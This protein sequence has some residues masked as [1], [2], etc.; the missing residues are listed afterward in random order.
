VT[1]KDDQQPAYRDASLPVEERVADLL[2]RMTLDE[3]VSQMVAESAAIPRLGIPAYEW[4]GECLHGLCQGGR[5]TVFPQAIGLAATFDVD[6][7]RRVAGAIADEARAKFHDPVWHGPDGPFVGLTFWTPVVNIFRDPRWGRGQETYGEDPHLTGAIG[8]AF[9][10]GLQGDDARRVKASACAKHFAVHSGPEHLRMGFDAVV[11]GKDLRETYLPAFRALAEAGVECFMGAYNRVN[12][13]PCC[14]SHMLLVDILRDE[15]GFEGYVVSDASA[16]PAFHESHHVTGDAVESAAL[17]LRM[18]CDMDIGG[19]CFPELPAAVEKGLV[20]EAEVDRSLARLLTSRFRL[21]LFDDPDDVPFAAIRSDVIQ[22][23]E[24]VALARE[25]AVK[26]VVLLKNSGILPF[27]PGV[28]TV[29][30]TGPN[31]ADLDVLLG[32][33]Y[34]G[35]S[36]RLV[37]VLE[38]VAECASEGTRISNAKGCHLLHP[39]EYPSDWV[40]GLAEWA[41]VV[42]AVMGIS[43]LMEGEG[44]ECIASV[45][46]G[47]RD[48]LA[49]PP[50]QVEFVRFL[51]GKG[52]PIVLV[53]T[54]GS[55]VAAPELHEL[56]DAVLFIWYPGEQGGRAV[57]QILFGHES[58]SGRLPVT[59]PASQDQVPPFE[60]YSMAGRTYRYMAEEPLYPFGFGLSYAEFEYGELALSAGR[61]ER[62]EGLSAEVT[63]TN[64]GRREAEEVV[65]LYVTDDEAS[66]AAPRCALKAFRRVRLASGGSETVRFD[67]TP[68]MMELVDEEGR[69]VLEPGTFTVT[70]G[71]SSPGPRAE[72][73][74]AARPGTARF[75][76]L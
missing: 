5:A 51:A 76:L 67:I 66:V 19:R 21:G 39:N 16:I 12:G 4:G 28:R 56:A 61:V 48:G 27:G 59:F 58:P 46:G 64:T 57:G 47:D 44:G 26:S 2:G 25:A 41:D 32:N 6:L 52:K 13:E 20:T 22:C 49:L 15:W 60:D 7:V 37:S 24:H 42:V 33:F 31:F 55:P 74:G 23:E 17:A 73:L 71:G 43:P 45:T 38:G 50:N 11:S 72:A 3:K 30:V 54:G 36:A 10:R 68:E 1:A 34:R 65:Q 8:A 14:G 63:V 62:G 40:G 69:P 53:L 35:V 29:L 70:A 9:V 75:E 18:G